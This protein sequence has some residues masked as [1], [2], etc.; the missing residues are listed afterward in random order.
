MRPK[1]TLSLMAALTVLPLP[2]PADGGRGGAA[3]VTSCGSRS[4]Y[5][6]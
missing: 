2:A 4:P 1:L 3:W 5:L 6:R